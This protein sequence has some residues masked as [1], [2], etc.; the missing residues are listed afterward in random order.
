MRPTASPGAGQLVAVAEEV[1]AAMVDDGPGQLVPLDGPA[2]L[3]EPVYAWVD[4]RA[5]APRR[6]VLA[7]GVATA[8]DLTRALLGLEPG[9]PVTEDDLRDAFGEIANVVGGSLASRTAAGGVL[10][11]PLVRRQ[12]PTA[13]E[14]P[15]VDEVAVAWR[16]QPLGITVWDG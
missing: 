2:D 1:F 16:G 11:L 3:V 9:E 13:G 7:T 14:T 6:V 8:A 4:V 10:T 12:A 15:P 5:D